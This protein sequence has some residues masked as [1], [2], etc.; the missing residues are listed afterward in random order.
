MRKSNIRGAGFWSPLI[1]WFVPLLALTSLTLL[2][3]VGWRNVGQLIEVHLAAEGAEAFQ[4][5]D[6]LPGINVLL[7]ESAWLLLLALAGI[8]RAYRDRLWSAFYLAAWLFTAYVLLL[9]NRPTWPHQQLLIT[10]PAA[11]LAAIAGG[12]A[13]GDLRAHSRTRLVL[14][15][16][17]LTL[18]L[19]FIAARGPAALREFNL[20]L[21]NLT[22]PTV[23]DLP[24]RQMVALLAD[25]ASE[26]TWVF[27]DRPMFAFQA[28]LPVPP[29][30]AVFSSKRLQTGEL[31]DADILSTLEAYQPEMILRGRFDLPIVDEF[32]RTRNYRRID[33]S[34]HYRL[35]LRQGSP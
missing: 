16:G 20:R 5:S 24:E 27:T 34:Y 8:Y 18:A 30:L 28:R 19:G 17:A 22:G 4:R 15:V 10:I 14:A 32:M 35:Y 29:F 13:I 6:L 12:A 25:H 26:T 11:V 1:T 2:L 31:S 9:V 33:E 23:R 3:V 7:K 21:P